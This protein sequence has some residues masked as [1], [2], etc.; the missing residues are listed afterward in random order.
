M[1]AEIE[2]MKENIA[3]LKASKVTYLQQY[4]STF[5]TYNLEKLKYCT[6]ELLI[7]IIS[8]ALIKANTLSRL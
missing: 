5:G 7:H 3:E 6:K 2:L 8:L 1:K 4:E